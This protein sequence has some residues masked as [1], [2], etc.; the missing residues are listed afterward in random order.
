MTK[1]CN[2]CN[3]DKLLKDFSNSFATPDGKQNQC[4]ECRLNQQRERV[5]R[6][7]QY[8]WFVAHRKKTWK[9]YNDRQSIKNK[10]KNAF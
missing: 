1:H 3:K 10:N 5:K 8:D 6:L 9:I 4:K 2:K 7:S